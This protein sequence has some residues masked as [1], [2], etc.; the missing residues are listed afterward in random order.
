MA[1][2]EKTDDIAG[3][4]TRQVQPKQAPMWVMWW[5]IAVMLMCLTSTIARNIYDAYHAPDLAL[6]ARTVTDLPEGTYVVTDTWPSKRKDTLYLLVG[7]VHEQMHVYPIRC[8]DALPDAF[9]LKRSK[10]LVEL[11]P[12]NIRVFT[13]PPQKD[14]HAP[15][16]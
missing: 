16:A 2:A 4:D 3:V 13:P 9:E 6:V 7:I 12:R 11:M 15:E 10:G 5:C 14:I 1:S 8:E